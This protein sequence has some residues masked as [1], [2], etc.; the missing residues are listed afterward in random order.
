MAAA[1]HMA[2]VPKEQAASVSKRPLGAR[3]RFCR[4]CGLPLTWTKPQAQPDYCGRDCKDARNLLDALER[5]ISRIDWP[6]DGPRK[7]FRGEVMRVANTLWRSRD[8]RRVRG[9]FAQK[10]R[11]S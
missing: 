9:R 4:V 7:Q 11:S 10:E 1:A 6:E 8:Q 5:A 3:P 2:E